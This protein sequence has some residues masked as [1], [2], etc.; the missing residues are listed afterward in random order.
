M[1]VREIISEE[2]TAVSSPSSKSMMLD[3][4]Q[5]QAFVTFEAVPCG[6]CI[7][8]PLVDGACIS[9]CTVASKKS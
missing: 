5:K 6:K 8:V 2:E 9:V 4:I 7:Y 3:V 1:N